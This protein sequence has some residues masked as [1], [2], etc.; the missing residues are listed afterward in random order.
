[1]RGDEFFVQVSRR[2][3]F[4]K[5]HPRV[6]GFFKE[7]F[8][9]EK[10]VRLGDRFVVNTN[11]PPYPS[12]AFGQLV[13]GYGSFGD[14]NQR[15]LYSVTMAVTNRCP[16]RCWHC[17]NAGRSPAD[18]PLDVWRR[19]A[20][21]VQDLG[22]VMVT[23]TGGE[24]LLR[25]D[26]EEIAGLFDDRSCLVLGTTG[27]GL[28]TKRARALRQHGLFAVGISLD[29]IDEATH[30]RLRGRKG[31]FQTAVRAIAVARDCELYAYTVHGVWYSKDARIRS[32]L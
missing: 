30:D 12:R 20:P 31:A 11:F 6:A 29:S 22:A 28:T 10:V 8:A 3:P 32:S 4:T 13:D 18:L 9:E 16:Y 14:A 26:L 15:R 1:M 7:Y 24:P 17:Y 2:P 5:L 25:D 27:A 19:L 21:E 23:L